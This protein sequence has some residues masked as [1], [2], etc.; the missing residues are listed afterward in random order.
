MKAF[1]NISFL[2]IRMLMSTTFRP[3]LA[4]YVYLIDRLR[5]ID[6]ESRYPREDMV[7]VR[8]SLRRHGETL[9]LLAQRLD[10]NE[11]HLRHEFETREGE[12]R[13]LRQSIHSV[14]RELEMTVTRL[15]DNQ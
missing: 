14:G 6:Q 15:T 4:A 10:K 8:E 1:A 3:A 2:R 5:T 9:R 13:Q 7:E 11:E 12:T